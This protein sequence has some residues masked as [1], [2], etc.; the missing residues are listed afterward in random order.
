MQ[1]IFREYKSGDEEGIIEL[2]ASVFSEYRNIQFTVDDWL[3]LEKKDEGFTRKNAFVAEYNG[4]IVG[5]VQII[6][7]QLRIG[8]AYITT[9]GIANV[10]TH[11]KFR[12]RGIATRL[13]T[14]A[15]KRLREENIPLSSLFT[16]YRGAAHRVY[17]KIGF[18]DTQ[19]L[20]RFYGKKMEAEKTIK[21][22]E[23]YREIEIIEAEK[24]D[25]EKLLKIYM[26][27]TMKISASH[28]RSQKYMKE[29]ILEGYYETFIYEP[30]F[31]VYRVLKDEETIGYFTLGITDEYVRVKPRSLHTANLIEVVATNRNTIRTV[32]REA[33]KQALEKKAKELSLPIQ[34][35]RNIIKSLKS[36]KK[37]IE[38]GIYMNKII[39][40]KTLLEQLKPELEGNLKNKPDIKEKIGII[41]EDQ[42]ITLKIKDC[43]VEVENNQA[44]SIIKTTNEEL[45]KLIYGINTPKEFILNSEIKTLKPKQ[46]KTAL[47]AMFKTKT[48]HIFSADTW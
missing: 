3:I 44:E 41:T 12:E 25:A 15:I 37:L 45:I 6:Y 33:I 10:A 48:L 14:L 36:F 22:L 28:K 30:A 9:G 18:T 27:Y 31:K 1:L 13:L 43:Q 8:R 5:H 23:D 38:G 39:N 47:R 20:T 46:L 26:K 7:R 2:L 32:L 17:R 35:T 29:K 34:S 42:Q 19:L 24:K 4:R 40:L 21:K 16:G 11:Q